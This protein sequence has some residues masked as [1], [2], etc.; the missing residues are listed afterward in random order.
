MSDRNKNPLKTIWSWF[1]TATGVISL[2]SFAEQV[3]GQLLVWK[4]FLAAIIDAYR[5]IAE[6]VFSFVFSISPFSIPSW[7]GDYCVVGAIVAASY[8]REAM[9]RAEPSA[10]NIIKQT[11]TEDSPTTKLLTFFSAGFATF[12]C[13]VFIWPLIFIAS[14]VGGNFKKNG[15][16]H[17]LWRGTWLLIC[18]IIFGFIVLLSLNS[19]L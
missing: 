6:P 16:Q 1:G 5:T 11:F 2:S 13:L 12:F 8:F 19:Q 3:S 15:R 18:S 14:F 17:E 9:A 4:D 7:V 10:W